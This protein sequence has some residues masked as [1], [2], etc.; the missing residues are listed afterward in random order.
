MNG[1]SST[2]RNRNG[3]ARPGASSSGRRRPSSGVGLNRYSEQDLTPLS[4]LMRDVRF[5]DSSRSAETLSVEPFKFLS[6]NS[7][8]IKILRNYT[9]VEAIKP[10]ANFI[11]MGRQ[12]TPG[13]V[14]CM[15]VAKVVNERCSDFSFVV[16]FTTCS[17][18]STLSDM[19]HQTTQ[20]TPN[21]CGGHSQQVKVFKA[22]K[23]ES[24]VTFERQ[25]NG[26]IYFAIDYATPIRIQFDSKSCDVNLAAQNQLTPYIQLSGN[27]LSLKMETNQIRKLYVQSAIKHGNALGTATAFVPPAAK[28]HLTSQTELKLDSEVTIQVT[29]IYN[30]VDYAQ[31][32]EFGVITS[33]R[34][35]I[36]FNER[37]FMTDSANIRKMSHSTNIEPDIKVNDKFTLTRTASGAIQMKKNGVVQYVT[38][39]KGKLLITPNLSP[40][41]I[42]N[43]TVSGVIINNGSSDTA[44]EFDQTYDFPPVEFKTTANIELTNGTLITWTQN[45]KSGLIV[46]A[47]PFDSV[48]KFVIREIQISNKAHSVTFGLI[49]SDNIGFKTPCEISN[50][51]DMRHEN[52]IPFPALGLRFSVYKTPY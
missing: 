52:L 41:V 47:K 5:N 24:K 10:T 35:Q 51:L 3:T 15:S 43:G 27:V 38:P 50:C 17:P 19:R 20:C 7:G 48:L 1:L 49:A 28:R 16:G 33:D 44:M 13:K 11:Y 29:K 26:D 40:F 4:S 8:D 37:L 14:F 34:N 31:G 22:N 9:V 32:F 42:L 39:M 2:N 6:L 21:G 18:A 36:K 46:N 12:L 23:I 25:A 45:G 30:A